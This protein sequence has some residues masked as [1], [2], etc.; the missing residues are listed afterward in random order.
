MTSDI[1]TGDEL[2]DELLAHYHALGRFGHR[3][4][5]HMC[6]TYLLRDPGHVHDAV[7]AFVR[8][9]ARSHGEPDRYHET[10]TRFWIRAVELALAEATEPA[11]F[12]ALLEEH[13]S[14]LDAR[15]PF[16]H[17]SRGLLLGPEARARFV[18]PDLLTL[19][20]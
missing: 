8:L 20:A 6:W 13:P 2:Q 12:E 11:D 16:R 1:S 4:H 18:E 15:L 5:L 7:P 9:V 17:Y 14:L 10:M 19:P 3:E